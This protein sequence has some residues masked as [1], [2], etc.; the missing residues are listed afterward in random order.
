MTT[1][2]P[3]MKVFKGFRNREEFEAECKKRC[4]PFDARQHDKK[5]SDFVD[6]AFTHDGVYGTALVSMFNG[7][8][9]G[10][11]EDGTE[12]SSDKTTHE[13]E[14][15]FQALLEAVYKV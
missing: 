11:L 7:R 9:F 12:F 4:W 10:K 1:T 3:A 6:V 5:G 15:W 2:A 13:G 8:F 14:P